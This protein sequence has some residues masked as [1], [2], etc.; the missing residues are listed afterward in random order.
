MTDFWNR[1]VMAQDEA[2]VDEFMKRLAAAPPRH[3]SALPEAE[4]LW[5]KAQLL[6]RWE[7]ERK[8]QIPLDIMEPVQLAAGLALASLLLVWSLPSLVN[9]LSSIAIKISGI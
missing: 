2:A 1:R 6:R 3:H 8:V 5:L 4:V 9:A 7:A